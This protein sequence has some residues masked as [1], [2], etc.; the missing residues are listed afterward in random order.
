MNENISG[1]NSEEYLTTAELSERIKMTPG[2][3]R[4]LVWKNKFKLNIHYHKPTSRKLLFIW[5]NV[6]AW[7][8]EN[9]INAGAKS[10]QGSDSLI[11]I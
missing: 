1:S 7:L 6:Q 5:G 11:H 8:R 4:N 2:T 9:S 10:N 3:I